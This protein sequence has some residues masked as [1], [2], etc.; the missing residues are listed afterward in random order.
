M[1]DELRFF[2]LPKVRTRHTAQF[3][4]PG[5]PRVW[6]LLSKVGAGQKADRAPRAEISEGFC[7]MG[8]LKKV[9]S[10]RGKNYLPVESATEPL[11]AHAAGR[12][13]L[14]VS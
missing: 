1:Y 11:V 9:P 8:R 3:K 10:G 13:D 14:V 6:L 2:L 5:R 12:S 7:Q 4:T